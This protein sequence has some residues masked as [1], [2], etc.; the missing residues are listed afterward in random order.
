MRRLCTL[1]IFF[2]A[3]ISARAA[4]AHGTVGGYTFIEPL[5]A[6]DANPKNEF[7]ILKPSWYRT[8]E[9]R[10]F[11]IGFSLE[12]KLSENLS[13]E[14]ESAWTDLSP[15]D[16][17]AVSGFDNLEMMGKYAFLTDPEH[18]LRLSMAATMSLPTGNPSA[19]AETHARLG[20]EILW[21][22]GFGD[23]P[24]SAILK[25]L[26]PFGIDGDFGYAPALSGEPS[27]E[28]FADNVVEYSFPYLSNNVKDIGL[29]WPLRNLYLFTEFNYDQL[30]TGP[31]GQTFPD[32]R[33]TP[34]VAFMNYYI[35]ISVGTQVPLNHAAVADDHAAV[36][37]L[38]DLFIDDIFPWTNW[39]PI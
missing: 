11:S 28:M 25:Y 3:F 33:V 18:E 38:L 20:P 9:G 22:K 32:I 15:K 16:S 13:L 36:L 8:A 24:N 14:M 27:H 39:T 30:I 26:R 4:F 37:G 19:G 17:G 2:A 34:G 21:A 35:Q 31:P 29:P 1:A 23:I 12:K 10:E 5:I 7:D 6:G